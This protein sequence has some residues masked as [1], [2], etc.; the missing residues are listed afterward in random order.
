MLKYVF[1]KGVN[2]IMY[3]NISEI[4]IIS[5]LDCDEDENGNFLGQAEI[6]TNLINQGWVILHF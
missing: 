3:T 5:S 1:K 4:K 2:L 6:V